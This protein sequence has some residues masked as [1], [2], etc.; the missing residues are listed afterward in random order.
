MNVMTLL[1]LALLVQDDSRELELA[2]RK[3]EPAAGLR[4]DLFAGEPQLANPVSLWVDDRGRVYVAETHRYNTSALYVKQHSHWYF[5]DLACRTV[6]DREAMARKYMGADAAKL[7]VQSEIVRL[8][9]DRS[10]TG[11]ADVSTVF[12]DGFNSM[13]D[14][15]ASGVIARGDDVWLADVPNLWHLRPGEKRVL[16]TGFGVRFGNSGHDLH[17]LVFGPDGKLYFSMGDRGLNVGK[18]ALPDTGAVLRCNPD[19]SEL[20]VF[21]TGLRNPQGLTFDALGNLW[22]GDNNADMGDD[23]RWVYVVEGGD[24]GWRTGFQY[25]TDPWAQDVV[26]PGQPLT[27][28]KNC[29]WMTEEIWKGV[30][31]WVVP[32]VGFISRGPCGV[33]PYPGTGLSA[34]YDGHF[35][36]CDFPGGLHS[37]GVQPK[38]ASYELTDVHRFLWQGWPTDAKFGPDGRLYVADWVHG[39]PMTGKGRIFRVFDPKEVASPIVMETKAL[40]N[41]GLPA[42]RLE[43]LLSHVDLRIRQNAQVALVTK[44]DVESLTRAARSAPTL[45]GRLHGIW[46]LGQLKA[47]APVGPLLEDA[48]PEVRAQ[49]ARMLGDLRAGLHPLI[50]RLGDAQPRVRFMAA[51]ALGKLGKKEAFGPLVEMIRRNGDRD[52]FLRHAGVMGL[53]GTGDVQGLAALSKHDSVSVRVAA[54]LAL[55]RLERDEVQGFLD[56]PDPQVVLEA[57]RAISDVPIPGAQNALAGLLERR[58]LQAPALLRAI[59]AN[60][61]RGTSAEVY[62]LATFAGDKDSPADLRAE[63]IQALAAWGNPTGRDRLLGIWRPLPPRDGAPAAE[64]LRGSLPALLRDPGVQQ[65]AIR[66]AVAVRLRDP[67]LEEI[68]RDRTKP[69]ALRAEALRA[70]VALGD[71]AT[72]AAIRAAVADKDAAYQKEGVTLLPGL[73][74]P[75]ATELLSGLALGEGSIEIRQAAISALPRVGAESVQIELMDRL[76]AGKVPAAL[77]FDVLEATR[78]TATLDARRRDYD[79]RHDAAEPLLEGGDVR[80]GK[81]IFYEHAG[82]ACLRCHKIGKE[83][84]EV[85]PPLTGLGSLRTRAKILESILY[86]NKELVAGYGQ[87]VVLKDDGNVIVGRLRSETDQ[88]LVLFLPEGLE[89]RI[90]KSRIQARKPGLSAMPDDISKALSR[91]E[92]RNV[93]AFL[94]QLRLSDQAPPPL[95]AADAEGWIP[96]F[97][98]KNLDGWDGDPQ[99]WRVEKGYISG[100]ADK[101]A[102]NTFLIHGHKFGDFELEAK[103][104]LFRGGTFPNSG[105]QYRSVVADPKLWIVHGYQADIGETFWGLL[106]DEKGRG[107]LTP[108]RDEVQRA[109]KTDDWNLYVV[110]ARGTK[111]SHTINGVDCGEFEDLDVKARRLEGIIAFQ[112]HAPGQFEVRFKDVRIRNR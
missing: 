15:C 69:A 54:L 38:G 32:P 28:S 92:L 22:T 17:G 41:G 43:S 37:F 14:G 47:V 25:A 63:A 60:F 13:S 40:L 106:Y 58:G 79:S 48:E 11:R 33:T 64:A 83:G 112:Y 39:F 8:L 89:E 30:P 66:A 36:L 67:L 10:G 74:N 16:H 109:I 105:I 31:A 71:P 99:V 55:R 26:K 9:E 19:G 35:F 68:T 111:V 27:I 90:P 53:A 81:R 73:R 21:A 61:R 1:L 82:V 100:K 72:P 87:E 93:L 103:V 5:D 44:R 101:I 91:R 24:S 50:A 7:A 110:R 108:P 65:A 59:Q 70:L 107:R 57:A 80:E 12:A 51:I 23:A 94:G 78:G 84:G 86:P 42:D 3:L 75:L 4:I 76:E 98:G 49:A 62:R 20:E 6:E 34:R 85:G 102:K 97:N 18:F 56:D 104:Q 95:P 46:G 45:Y 96:L 29:A 52:A 88:E 2:V 77:A